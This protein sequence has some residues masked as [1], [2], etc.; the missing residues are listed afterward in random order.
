MRFSTFVFRN[1]LQRRIRSTLT[2]T[3]M[4]VAVTAVVALVGLSDGVNRT[5]LQQY[6]QRGVSLIVVRS[7]ELSPINTTMSEKVAHDIEAL[8]GVEATCP[9]LLK[10]IPI[11][12]CGVSPIVIQGWPA[13]NFM[14]GQIALVPGKGEILSEKNQG[15]KSVIVG[16]ELAHLKSV[17]VGD[18]L[19]IGGSGGPDDQYRVVGI[20]QSVADMENGM[21]VML[22]ED[23]QRA[24]GHT[25]LITGCTVRLRDNSEK[26]VQ[27]ITK[28]IETEIAKQ[29]DLTGVLRA[30]PPDAFVQTN[31]QMQ[32]FKWFAW[33]VSVIALVIGGIGV[34]NTMFMSVFER[35]REI[36][37]LRAIGWRRSA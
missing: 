25:G 2:I 7:D 31:G 34:L 10:V 26:N 1:V 22:L 32:V 3:G 12:E 21:V 17:K 19:T 27:A 35:T 6:V 20:F 4:A 9:G 37:I 30:K 14:F 36:G 33:A 8:D 28:T 16:R 15:Q 23:A 11:E 24:F 29:N 13:G 18:S 5:M